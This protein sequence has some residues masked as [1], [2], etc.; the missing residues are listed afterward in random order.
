MQNFLLRYFHA[1]R[2]T[3]NHWLRKT[4]GV[5]L[6]IGGCLGFLPVLGYWMLPLGLALLAVDFPTARRLNR[7]LIVAWGRWRRRVSR[8]AHARGR[9]LARQRAPRSPGVRSGP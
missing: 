7:R 1:L 5:L 3:N 6:V 9:V 4:I 8:E 2:K